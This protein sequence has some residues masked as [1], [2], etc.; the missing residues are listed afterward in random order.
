VAAA[1]WD[2]ENNGFVHRWDIATGAA[3]GQPISWSK[4]RSAPA[5]FA[6]GKVLAIGSP[7]KLIRIYDAEAETHRPDLAGHDGEV[8]RV[9]VAPD[10]K[11]LAS[12]G[13]WNKPRGQDVRLWDATTG[14]ELYKLDLTSS[15]A[16]ALVFSPD[17]KTLATGGSDGVIRLWKVSTG[18]LLREF[19]G[20]AA[21]ESLAFS[22]DGRRLA[23]GGADTAVVIWKV[24]D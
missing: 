21:I 23:A 1:R 13:D 11:T 4:I 16:T 7:D 2:D 24:G 22:A 20:P 19:K 3:L 15:Q 8:A 17:G 12:L 10:G 6:G 14:K 18:V 5:V 9:V